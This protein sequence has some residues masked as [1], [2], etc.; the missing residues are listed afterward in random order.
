MSKKMF[1]SGGRGYSARGIQDYPSKSIAELEKE[2][3]A[4]ENEKRLK[5]DRFYQKEKENYYKA[6]G[7]KPHG[8]DKYYSHFR[9]EFRKGKRWW[10]I[11]ESIIGEKID[12]SSIDDSNKPN[13]G[14]GIQSRL[15]DWYEQDKNVKK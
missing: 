12:I 4:I 7:K 14:K 1:K 5:E 2:K 11:A 9:G 3:D 10:E 6:I 13:R 15:K 8:S